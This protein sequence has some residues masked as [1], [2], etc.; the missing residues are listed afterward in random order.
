M[1]N[2]A[3]GAYEVPDPF[4]AVFQLLNVLLVL[5]SAPEFVR[6]VTVEPVRYGLEPSTGTVP[7]VEPLP[8][9]VTVKVIGVHCA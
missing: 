5:T 2:V 1:L 8:L 7:P 9:Y 4:A 6:T 3:A